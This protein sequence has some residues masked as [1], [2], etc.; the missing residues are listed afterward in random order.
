MF[1][2]GA[3]FVSWATHKDDPWYDSHHVVHWFGITKYKGD[4]SFARGIVLRR[5]KVSILVVR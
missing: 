5:F 4:K 2:Y 3:L 1:K